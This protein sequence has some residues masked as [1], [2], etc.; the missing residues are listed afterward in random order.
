[1]TITRSMYVLAVPDLARSAEF[2][3]R[4]LGFEAQEMGDPGWRMF[5]N[6]ECRIMAGECP[7]ALPAQE[8]GDHSYF[9]YLVVDDVRAY[10]E[11]ARASGA[12]IVKG[13]RDEPWG[14]REF[15]LRTCDGHR[16][17]VG[18]ALDSSEAHSE[19]GR[20]RPRRTPLLE[21]RTRFVHELTVETEQGLSRRLSAR[22][23]SSVHRAAR[24]SCLL[25][26]ESDYTRPP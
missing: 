26:T 14:M 5:V 3:A 2:Y 23:G 20:W 12:E 15:G 16:I 6:G 21:L 9:A 19:P 1:M 4:A 11:R 25:H 17:M 18:Q 13:L 7:G 10:H 22:A 24:I 8:L